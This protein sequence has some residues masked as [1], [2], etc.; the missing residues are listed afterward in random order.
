MYLVYRKKSEN[1][2]DNR[3]ESKKYM[4]EKSKF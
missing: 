1:K 2:K 3:G 4:G